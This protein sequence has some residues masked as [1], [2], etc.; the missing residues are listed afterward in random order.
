M[1]AYDG[2]INDAH[3]LARRG[4]GD[5]LVLS[6]TGGHRPSEEALRRAIEEQLT[7]QCASLVAACD[8]LGR[9]HLFPDE[10]TVA[11]HVESG[12][13]RQLHCGS[14][15][16]ESYWVREADLVT[17][18]RVTSIDTATLEPGATMGP[19]GSS[20]PAAQIAAGGTVG[21]AS[22]SCAVKPCP[23]ESV[24]REPA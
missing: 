11:A 4:N 6:T 17:L 10:A 1:A 5:V 3:A 8:W 9:T 15:W 12:H 24:D 13:V 7:E 20:S 21:P 16:C 2:P 22:Q 18:V 14:G 19:H 23:P